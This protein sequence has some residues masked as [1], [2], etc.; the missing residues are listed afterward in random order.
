MPGGLAKTI[1][2]AYR[3]NQEEAAVQ[4]I[5]LDHIMLHVSDLE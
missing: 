2:P 1:L 5:G 3:V 4:P